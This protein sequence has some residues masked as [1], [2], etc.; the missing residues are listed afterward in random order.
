M[1]KS[2]KMFCENKIQ[3]EGPP[4]RIDIR[5]DEDMFQQKHGAYYIN[6]Y[7]TTEEKYKSCKAR[8]AA[9][10]KGKLLGH[11]EEYCGPYPQSAMYSS[12]MDTKYFVNGMEVN[13]KDWTALLKEVQEAIGMVSFGKT[14]NFDYYRVLSDGCLL[15]MATR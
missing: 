14:M 11:Y 9:A 4:R 13:S 3:E 6:G 2:F 7:L 8:L 10:W 12:N 15:Y 5:D 1:Y